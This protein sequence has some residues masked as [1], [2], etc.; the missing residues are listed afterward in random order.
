MGGT[1]GLTQQHAAGRTDK[2]LLA[3][4]K[5]PQRSQ[6]HFLPT[7]PPTEEKKPISDWLLPGKH[8]QETK[9]TLGLEEAG[10]TPDEPCNTAAMTLLPS[11]CSA[12]KCHLLYCLSHLLYLQL[13]V[14]AQQ[15][16]PT[17]Q[18]RNLPMPGVGI[19][20]NTG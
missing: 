15:H 12:A 18:S 9:P 20:S 10:T 8:E 6:I 7:Q 1:W 16:Q 19:N 13:T 11:S 5:D 4:S 3:F 2:L 14:T 17:T